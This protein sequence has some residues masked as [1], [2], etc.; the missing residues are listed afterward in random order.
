MRSKNVQKAISD[1]K[2]FDELGIVHVGVNT[3]RIGKYNIGLEAMSIQGLPR[4]RHAT[5]TIS[6]ATATAV[7]GT[8]AG[9]SLRSLGR[10]GM[11][12]GPASTGAAGSLGAASG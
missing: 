7:P 10:R 2:A 11:R 9:V 3:K 12:P 6:S 5:T 8:T 4:A 1:S